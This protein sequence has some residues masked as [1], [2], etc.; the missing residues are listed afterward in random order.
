MTNVIDRKHCWNW[1]EILKIIQCL[2][3]L[4]YS[5]FS[6][7]NIPQAF[8]RGTSDDPNLYPSSELRKMS[9]AIGDMFAFTRLTDEIFHQILHSSTPELKESR[10]ILHKILTRKL[11]KCVGQTQTKGETFFSRVTIF[12]Y[13]INLY[14]L[15]FWYFFLF[16]FL[17]FC[18]GMKQK[19]PQWTTDSSATVNHDHI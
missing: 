1:E 3:F 17:W 7:L 9:D 8:Q 11:Y 15:F 4:V 16:F 10:D 13:F 2:A 12:L 18:R 6:Y 14:S 5:A 19:T